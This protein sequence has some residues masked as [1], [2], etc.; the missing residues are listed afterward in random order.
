M[1]ISLRRCGIMA[2]CALVLSGCANVKV[3]KVPTPTQYQTWSDELQAKADTMEGFRF[4]LPR[5]F[6]NVFESFPVHADV[7]VIEGVLSPDG[8]F[9]FVEV[10]ENSK[11]STL[12]GKVGIG[13]TISARQIQ[14]PDPMSIDRLKQLIDPNTQVNAQNTTEQE[15]VDKPNAE[16]GGSDTSG[17][18]SQPAAQPTGQNARDV[19]N[20]NSAYAYQPMRGHMDIVFLPDFDEQ[21]TL[22]SKANLGNAKFQLNLGQGWSLQ[23]FNSLTDNSALNDRIF[24]LMDE[25]IDLAKQAAPTLL[26]LP[27]LPAGAADAIKPQSGRALDENDKE[28]VPGTPV[29]LRISVVHYAAKGLYPV[30]KPRELKGLHEKLPPGGQ[31]GF[32]LDVVSGYSG[33]G[34]MKANPSTAQPRATVPVYPY[35]YISF[36]TFQYLAIELIR[37]DRAPFENL[38]DKTGTAGDPGDAQSA[39]FS[40]SILPSALRDKNNPRNAESENSG[41]SP[42]AVQL[43]ADALSQGVEITVENQQLKVIKAEAIN[44]KVV[45][46]FDKDLPAGADQKTVKQRLFDRAFEIEPEKLTQNGAHPDLIALA[47]ADAAATNLSTAAQS[48]TVAPTQHVARAR[49]VADDSASSANPVV[50]SLSKAEIL[51]IQS[52]LC[53]KGPFLNGV[54]GAGM[55]TA[56]KRYQVAENKDPANGNLTEELRSELL[57]LDGDAIARLCWIH[58]FNGDQRVA[59]PVAAGLGATEVSAVQVALCLKGRQVDGV[60]GPITQG[61]LRRW[62]AAN[63]QDPADGVLTTEQAQ[64]LL[65]LTGQSVAISCQ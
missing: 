47:G 8:K 41:A 50:K 9:V 30:I 61:A 7:Y 20:D 59:D 60:W 35:Q 38:Y 1:N 25:A 17:A 3:H 33:T 36:N 22:S 26:G 19:T 32:K 46:T 56:I 15:K 39:D 12:L 4:Y 48:T 5:P 16:S 49:L 24:S 53:L 2:A 10:P 27:P 51:A 23:G 13:T 11:L 54:W 40:G 18:S 55:S 63:N 52:A 34:E 31:G 28:A 21:Y 44:D 14:A 42:A 43:L 37:S 65:A 57:A 64:Q 6:I 62:Q 29:S 58:P 45:V